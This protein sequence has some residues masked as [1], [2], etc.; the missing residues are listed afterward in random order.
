MTQEEL[1]NNAFNGIN[2]KAVYVHNLIEFFES[3]ACT[4]RGA[5]RHPY[6]DIWHQAFEGAEIQKL[7]EHVMLMSMPPQQKW[8]NVSLPTGT[9][10]LKPNNPV[11]E[12]QWMY[13][14]DSMD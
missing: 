9:Y 12:W 11:Y 5:N 6:A 14:H 10:R 3:N 4:Q 2:G 13:Q 8:D 7:D 1:L